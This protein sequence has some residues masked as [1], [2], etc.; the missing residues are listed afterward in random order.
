VPDDV[1]LEAVYFIRG[2]GASRGLEDYAVGDRLFALR[3]PF[4]FVHVEGS[5]AGYQAVAVDYL[6]YA[7]R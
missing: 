3:D 5:A 2:Q 7:G 6:L 1:A 4:A